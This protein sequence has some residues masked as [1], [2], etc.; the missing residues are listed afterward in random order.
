MP[1]DG[2]ADPIGVTNLLAKAAKKEGAQ[3]FEKSP[4]EKIIKKDGLFVFPSGFGLPSIDKNPKYHLSFLT[5][6]ELLQSITI[7]CITV[8][9]FSIGVAVKIPNLEIRIKSSM[10]I[11]LSLLVILCNLTNCFIT[12]YGKASALTQ[13]LFL[14]DCLYQSI[15]GRLKEVPTF[16]ILNINN[17]VFSV[18]IFE[19]TEI[20]I[21][22]QCQFKTN[23]YKQ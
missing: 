8:I 16:S 17:S 15:R 1:G 12:L 20:F 18:Y 9:L 10:V 19:D 7:H 4:V 2:Q 13:F 3:I 21:I 14:V 11:K 6:I 5:L 23:Y 22:R